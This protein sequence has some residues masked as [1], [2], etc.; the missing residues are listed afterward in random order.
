MLSNATFGFVVISW[1]YIAL[2]VWVLTVV[3][4][5][6]VSAQFLRDPQLFLQD[7]RILI[8]TD[9]RAIG[10][11]SARTA[12]PTGGGSEL[13]NPAL[14]GILDK[15]EFTL[16]SLP[17]TK[18]S[19]DREGAVSLAMNLEQLQ[20]SSTDMGNISISSWVDGWGADDSKSR[21]MLIGYGLDLK[22]GFSTG[23]SLRHH[24]RNFK[25][26]TKIGWGLDLGTTYTRKLPRLGDRVLFG[27]ALSDIGG[28]FWQGGKLVRDEKMPLILRF[29]TTYYIDVNTP[30]SVDLAWHDDRAYERGDRLRFHLGI[31]RSFFHNLLFR[32][33]YS[34]LMNYAKFTEGTWTHGVGFRRGTT[35]IDYAYVNNEYGVGSHWFSIAVSWLA[36]SSLDKPLDKPA[37]VPVIVMPDRLKSRLTVS[38][39]V[40][41]PNGDGNRDQTQLNFIM[42]EELEWQLEIQDRQNKIVRQFSGKGAPSAPV[43][44]A[45]KDALQNIVVDG[46]YDVYLLGV[47]QDKKQQL[48]SQTQ[49]VIDTKPISFE[50]TA[51]PIILTGSGNKQNAS[52]ALVVQARI[53]EP[54]QVDH[55]VLQFFAGENLVDKVD[56]KGNP[57][58]PLILDFQKQHVINSDIEHSC[59]LILCD[60][61]GNC[62]T[63]LVKIQLIDLREKVVH[64]RQEQR[65]FVLTLPG[66]IFDTDSAKV[67]SEFHGTLLQISDAILAYP[68]AH[69]IIEGHTDDVGDTNYNL[70][71]SEKR[72]NVVMD[73]L[74]ANFAVDQNRISSVGYGETRRITENDTPEN[75]QINRRVEIILSTDRK[76]LNQ[77][78]GKLAYSYTLLASSFKDR[79]NAETLVDSLESFELDHSAKIVRVEVNGETWYRVTVGSFSQKADADSLIQ[80]IGALLKV[81]PITIMV[82][83]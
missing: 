50:I 34:S 54:T 4:S 19:G 47:N 27:L 12:G 29:G 7:R 44:W 1:R 5:K 63:Q 26:I 69:V 61:A 2:T 68:K 20:V 28:R 40:I 83:N 48:S 30:F 25:T 13:W 8:G 33:G 60:L 21:M 24:R 81:K 51:D 77:A 80:R 15:T 72:A 59:V 9:V 6:S 56:G 10:M 46:V 18:E 79:K 70:V 45:G 32:I 75:R 65:G 43:T 53:S 23:V 37:S 42:R 52:T 64:G 11:G 82:R 74:I 36:P 41:S 39:K 3:L 14:I 73:Y 76:Q 62:A 58:S 31:E 38:D 66:I 16:T 49:V 35:Q 78:E 57:S 17:F 71:L 67:K 55:W 22:N